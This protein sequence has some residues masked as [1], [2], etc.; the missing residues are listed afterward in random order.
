M[1][2]LGAQIVL[3]N[4]Y[5]LHLRPGEDLIAEFG[6]LHRFMGW[7]G[8]ILTDSGG[9]QIFSLEGLRRFSDDGVEFRSHLDGGKLFLRPEDVVGIQVRLGVDILM[10]LD[11]CLPSAADETTAR[12]ALRRTLDWA[13]RSPACSDRGRISRHR[14]GRTVS[15]LR[16]ECAA[17]LVPLGFPGHAVGGLSVGEEK[18]LTRAAD[19]TAALLPVERPRYLMGW[20]SRRT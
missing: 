2:E 12:T 1:R 15:E 3:S 20:A 6:G 16:R 17:A 7:D 5:H 10:P 11:E 14:A 4:P 19:L 13:Q 18:R 8:P 9:Y